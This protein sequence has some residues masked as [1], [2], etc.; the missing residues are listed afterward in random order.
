MFRFLRMLQVTFMSL[1]GHA[2]RA[3]LAALGVVLGVGAVVAMMAISEGARR[4]SIDRIRSMGIDNIVVRSV[5]PASEKKGDAPEGQKA[6]ADYGLR[7]EDLK[8]IRMTFENID[9]LVPV[10]DM[11]QIVRSE[12]RRTD[13]RIIATEPAFMEVTFSESA[14]PRGRWIT[15]LDQLRRSPVCVLG[16][17]AARTLFGFEDPLRQ[18][19]SAGG[20]TFEVVGL[21]RN[22]RGG[23]LAG[24]YDLNNLIYIPLET[25][26]ALYGSMIV[27]RESAYSF[28]RL[29]IDL[30][31]LY[32]R[33]KEVEYLLDTV[34]RLRSFL[35]QTHQEP[36]YELQVPY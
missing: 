4:E 25:A 21:L 31:Y 19:V 18:S 7:H 28:E 13:I 5:K 22:E 36:D 27:K 33:V 2:F 15:E 23:R 14:D 10:R 16:V 32:I 20:A 9:R 30:D 12:G 26:N 34:R 29:M 6:A 11:Q 3:F 17:K 1:G 8:H 35:E 24:T